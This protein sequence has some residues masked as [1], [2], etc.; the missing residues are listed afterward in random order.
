M[1]LPAAALGDAV[2]ATDLHA[3][4]LPTGAV[5]VLPHPFAGQLDGGLSADVR[6]GGRAAATAG[7]TATNLPPHL[8]SGGAFQRPPTNRGTVQGGSVTVRVNGKPAARAG[9]AVVTCNDPADLP[10]GTIQA[11]GPVRI[12]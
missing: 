2:V 5:A 7:S 4:V 3:V 6:I 8:P 12:G 11:A 9:D 1:G 10:V